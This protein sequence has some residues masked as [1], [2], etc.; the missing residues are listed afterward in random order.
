MKESKKEMLAK[1]KLE[2]KNQLAVLKGQEP[3]KYPEY[4]AIY[5]A[6]N[7]TINELEYDIRLLVEAID[8]EE[9]KKK[10]AK[11]WEEHLDEKK[12]LE[13][14]EEDIRCKMGI[15]K[16]SAVNRMNEV[17]EPIG[18]RVGSLSSEHIS[19]GIAKEDRTPNEFGISELEFGLNIDIYYRE[20]IK[21]IVVVEEDGE[22]KCQYEVS[23]TVEMNYGCMGS[24]D[25]M[26][27]S[28]RLSFVIAM[29]R[30]AAEENVKQSV[31]DLLREYRKEFIA[32]QKEMREID[33][34]I[35]NPFA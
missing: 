3:V 1:K 21:K 29:G 17:L 12:V 5:M 33:R 35:S 16:T 8:T 28:K 24:F 34:K 13:N 2:L 11:Y 15:L 25:I 4:E 10:V 22:K 26:V 32:L 23:H 30:F 7:S 18:M 19:I 14:K 9:T 6:R 31:V 20:N 27:E